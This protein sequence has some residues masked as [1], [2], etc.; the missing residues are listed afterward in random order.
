MSGNQR[1]EKD[2]VDPLAEGVGGDE[3]A[4]DERSERAADG[5]G[6]SFSPRGK[7]RRTARTISPEEAQH[8]L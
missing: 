2:P 8:A 6:A 3:V 7:P 5:A 4:A 1:D